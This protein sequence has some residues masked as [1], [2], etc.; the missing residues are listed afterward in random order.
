MKK[1]IMRWETCKKEHISQV[2]T[3]PA[4]IASIM[5]MASIRLE[6]RTQKHKKPYCL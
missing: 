5:K 1:E 2:E 3:D 6:I 4:K